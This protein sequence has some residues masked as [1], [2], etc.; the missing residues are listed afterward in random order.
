ML[1]RRRKTPLDDEPLVPHGLISQALDASPDRSLTPQSSP[2]LPAG[3]SVAK[4]PPARILKW[5]RVTASRT[6]GR[7]ADVV[8]RTFRAAHNLLH[9][10]SAYLIPVRD[11]GSAWT[12]RTRHA[13]ATLRAL[14]TASDN[15]STVQLSV[16][17]GRLRQVSSE[18]AQR[19]TRKSR[20]F[21]AR[22]ALSFVR[23]RHVTSRRLKVRPMQARLER[24]AGPRLPGIR[25][26]LSG[27]PL[28]V[29]I[30]FTRA[31]FKWNLRR[32]ALSRDSR[33][34]TALILS[35]ISAA[36]AAGIFSAAR[37]FADELL[38]SKR[39]PFTNS[40]IGTPITPTPAV[41]GVSTSTH[42]APVQPTTQRP[43]AKAKPAPHKPRNA[44]PP[45]PKNVRHNEEEDYVA[46]DTYVYYGTH[47]PKKSPD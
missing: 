40:Q 47:S 32:R 37:H 8:P 13:L 39:G 31:H 21:W 14:L 30:A 22:A 46:K 27:L 11:A 24:L 1:V 17:L 45:T 19:L 33:L 6:S 42:R 41:I 36:L 28:L 9:V 7:I 43:S 23:L 38:P 10:T 16:K 34:S 2:E 12:E 44:K 35:V 18:C 25:I 5:P 15:R 3:I 26:R 29:R 4:R 20:D